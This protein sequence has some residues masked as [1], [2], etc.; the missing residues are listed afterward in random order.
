MQNKKRRLGEHGLDASLDPQ[1]VSEPGDTMK[2][3]E[4][5]Q[6]GKLV[7]LGTCSNPN[8]VLVCLRSLFK[9]ISKSNCSHVAYIDLLL[10][11]TY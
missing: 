2:K 4:T 7:G 11:D 5:L 8:L 9:D 6:A 3:T 10:L 1:H